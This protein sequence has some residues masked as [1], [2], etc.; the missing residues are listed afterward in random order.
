MFKTE[1]A[2]F[3]WSTLYS[4]NSRMWLCD[5]MQQL[6]QYA[7]CLNFNVC[8]NYGTVGPTYMHVGCK[9]TPPFCAT[10]I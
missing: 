9:H 1:A 3:Y 2:R 10:C 7:L 4:V 8:L 5:V 6:L